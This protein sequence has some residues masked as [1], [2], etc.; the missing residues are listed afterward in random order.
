M[1]IRIDEKTAFT[2]RGDR[3]T[4]KAKVIHR[5]VGTALETFEVHV[6][7]PLSTEE[8]CTQA[9]ALATAV[10]EQLPDD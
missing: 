8:K 5:S 7:S 6:R 3:R 1:R 2:D 9:V 10:E 4:C